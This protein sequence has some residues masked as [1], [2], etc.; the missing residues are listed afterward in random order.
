M[1]ELTPLIS[2]RIKINIQATNLNKLIED[3]S[4][5]KN[6][7]T[8]LKEYI[9]HVDPKSPIH[10]Y[11]KNYKPLS[12]DKINDLIARYQKTKDS[13][14]FDELI[15]ANSKYMLSMIMKSK[16]KLEK[17]DS[18]VTTEEVFNAMIMNFSKAI[19]KFDVTKNLKFITY[20]DKWLKEVV[21][22]YKHFISK[23]S[24]IVKNKSSS[25]D[26]KI[27]K[28]GGK[29]RTLGD[30]IADPDQVDMYSE[31]EKSDFMVAL[32]K[33]GF[34]ALSSDEEFV[35]RAKYGMLSSK[36]ED[37]ILSG[38]GKVT[39]KTIGKFLGKT[40]AAVLNIHKRALL[41]LKKKLR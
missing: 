19:N 12:D 29:Q 11:I 34:S 25:L 8:L 5:C 16:H 7:D 37:K 31:K 38:K 15:K 2:K 14:A 24:R 35:I 36:L 1:I 27:G 17:V 39:N 26:M 6:T 20:L 32:S 40:G 18:N 3:I 33:R 9:G 30:L 28:G 22:N 41:K 10:Y 23:S 4:N 21:F 13:R